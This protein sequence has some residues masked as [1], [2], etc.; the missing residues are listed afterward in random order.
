MVVKGSLAPNGAQLGFSTYFGG[1]ATEEGDVIALDSFGNA[2]ITGLTR[3]T[4]LPMVSPFQGTAP[5]PAVAFVAKITPADLV[6]TGVPYAWG[7]N[8]FGQVGDGTTTT[9]PTPVTV[10][11]ATVVTQIADK[12]AKTRLSIVKWIQ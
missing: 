7:G 10:V 6:A 2:Y 1:S 12:T 5:G 3:S 8:V 4:D 11:N 9:R